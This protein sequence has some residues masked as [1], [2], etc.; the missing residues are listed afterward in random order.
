MISIRR[1]SRNRFSLASDPIAL[2]RMGWPC[3]TG[4]D[5]KS[6]LHLSASKFS[7]R[8]IAALCSELVQGTGPQYR[9]V[10]FSSFL[11]LNALMRSNCLF[12]SDEGVRRGAGRCIY[13]DSCVCFAQKMFSPYARLSPVSTFFSFVLTDSL[14][15]SALL[16]QFSVRDALHVLVLSGSFCYHRFL[17]P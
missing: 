5:L 14:Y 1:D 3:S 10:L 13:D 17:I 8:P 7:R 15:L 4:R 11:L 9:D 12:W 6:N 16:A 2:H